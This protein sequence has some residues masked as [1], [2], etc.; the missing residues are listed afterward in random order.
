MIEISQP[1]LSLSLGV[2]LL[3]QGRVSSLGDSFRNGGELN[4]W[5]MFY[6]GC[7]LAIGIAIVW[8]VARHLRRRDAGS[9]HNHRGLFR[10]LCGAH[11]LRW[12]ER[13]L[14]KK[15]ARQQRVIVP[16]RLFVEPE[17][18][19]AKCLDELRES[20]HRRAATLAES[21]FRSDLEVASD[22]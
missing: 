6:V 14:L 21:L 10:E 3:G 22:T 12:S 2:G 15:V 17:R 8:L 9:Y 7:V 4:W 18:F 20:Q 11:R 13:R 5:M 16:A 1:F 19:D